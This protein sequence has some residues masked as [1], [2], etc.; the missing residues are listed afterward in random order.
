MSDV[1]DYQILIYLS[2][3]LEEMVRG[4]IRLGWEPLGAPVVVYKETWAGQRLAQA[5]VMTR[6]E[7]R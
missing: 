4:E 1:V 3:D 2:E 5:M 6:K 7:D